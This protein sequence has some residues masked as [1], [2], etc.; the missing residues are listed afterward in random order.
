MGDG[1]EAMFVARL[2]LQLVLCTRLEAGDRGLSLAAIAV[3][4]SSLQARLGYVHLHNALRL[5]P[6]G[7]AGL[8][9]AAQRQVPVH[10]PAHAHPSH[11][12]ARDAVTAVVGQA[13]FTAQGV[14]R[15]LQQGESR[16]LVREGGGGP[17]AVVQDGGP[18]AVTLAITHAHGHGVLDAPEKTSKDL[19]LGLE[20]LK[21]GHRREFLVGDGATPVFIHLEHNLLDLILLRLHAQICQAILQ[22]VRVDLA[23]RIL[24]EPVEGNHDLLLLLPRERRGVVS[25]HGHVCEVLLRLEG[26]NNGLRLLFRAALIGLFQ[27]V[28]QL[29]G[30]LHV[31]EDHVVFLKGSAVVVR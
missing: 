8:Q 3:G 19:L 9:G 26:L 7:A 31:D 22:L 14:C 10:R 4:S 20:H 18:V 16:A 5:H 27:Y 29:I 21:R 11:L 1:A 12:H 13:E 30:L 28:G 24:V 2:H 17:Q 15:G 25:I 6:S 23:R